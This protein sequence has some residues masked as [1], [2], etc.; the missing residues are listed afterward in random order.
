VSRLRDRITT[1]LI[2][3]GDG[4]LPQ[5]VTPVSSD[6]RGEIF[7][8]ML[9]IPLVR[10]RIYPGAIGYQD[11]DPLVTSDGAP[12]TATGKGQWAQLYAV[13]RR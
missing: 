13:G 12:V 10:I 5:D 1:G 4:V 3:G 6:K 8:A 2:A 7:G 9:S 11:L